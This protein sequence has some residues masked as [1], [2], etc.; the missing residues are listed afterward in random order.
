MVTTWSKIGTSTIAADQVYVAVEWRGE[1][2]PGVIVGA[3]SV[4]CGDGDIFTVNSNGTTI[5]CRAMDTPDTVEY[6]NLVRDALKRD[7]DD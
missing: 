7:G 1:F 5:R 3:S 6:V 2:T 4:L